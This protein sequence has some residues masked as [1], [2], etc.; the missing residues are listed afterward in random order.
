[1]LLAIAAI[2]GAIATVLGVI[3]GPDGVVKPIAQ[4]VASEPTLTVEPTAV[5]TLIS[6]GFCGFFDDISDSS[7]GSVELG[8]TNVTVFRLPLSHSEDEVFAVRLLDSEAL[9]FMGGVK[10]FY[11]ESEEMFTVVTAVD[12]QCS[13]VLDFTQTYTVKS[14]EIFPL[15]I[16]NREYALQFVA[17]ARQI[18]ISFTTSPP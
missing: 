4:V 10:F 5:P 16:D 13:V 9:A 6:A 17:I 1:M 12:G 2:I 3:I 18:K 8:D 11:S 14:G 15:T 7:K